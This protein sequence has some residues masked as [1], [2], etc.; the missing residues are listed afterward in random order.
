MEMNKENYRKLCKE[1]TTIP[2][3][4]QDWWLDCVCG[5][6]KWNVLLVETQGKQIEA[7]MP[8]YM[9]H[10]GI[11]RMPDFSQSMGIW[12]NPAFEKINYTKNL[13]RKQQIC[14]FFI[15]NLPKHKTFF[16]G[17]HYSFSDWLPFYWNGFKQTT[18]YTYI[19]H[20]IKD[21]DLLY[22]S[23]SI[24]IKRNIAKA[25]KKYMIEIQRNI[26]VDLF[27]EQYSMTFK[28]QGLESHQPQI[29][30]KIIET[31]LLRQQGDI[32]GAYDEHNRL[33]ASVFIVWQNDCAYYIAA[34]SNPQLRK[35]GAHAYVL[36]KAITDLSKQV[37]TFDFEGSM[38]L[39][40][41]HFF[42]EFGAIQYPY[43][44]I[45]KGKINLFQKVFLKLLT[46]R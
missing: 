30:K 5:E 40:I 15:K 43:F 26:P 21:T 32:W 46:C 33:H 28:R 11:I 13:Y 12:F 38:L 31:C 6:S 10:K 25:K 23:F 34:G 17:F 37:K 20:D 3:Y 39:G 42:R 45:S 24:N 29:L 16:Q 8:F 41:E 35:S 19:L 4:S 2:L 44:F 22:N 1:E 14:D 18:R 7:A 9:P 36:W 27:I